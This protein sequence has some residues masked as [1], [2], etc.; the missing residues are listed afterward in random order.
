MDSP[1][2]HG[3]FW[4]KDWTLSWSSTRLQG[5]SPWTRRAWHLVVED[6][7][8]WKGNGDENSWIRNMILPLH[9]LKWPMLFECGCLFR[10]EM[11][12]ALVMKYLE[13][14]RSLSVF[15]HIEIFNFNLPFY[16]YL[17]VILPGDS[18]RKKLIFLLTWSISIGDLRVIL[19]F[20]PTDLELAACWFPT[21]AFVCVR[22]FPHILLKHPPVWRDSIF[23]KN[24]W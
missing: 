4:P 14:Y 16:M 18:M 6:S 21:F 22:R 5:P 2:F 23:L 1:R 24:S 12:R 11:Q 8:W 9:D 7:F 17:Q 19:N 20:Q 15:L 3:V 10:G 13:M